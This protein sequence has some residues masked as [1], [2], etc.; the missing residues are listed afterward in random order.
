MWMRNLQAS[1]CDLT[2]AAGE[3]ECVGLSLVKLKQNRINNKIFF[4][5]IEQNPDSLYH[6]F[7]NVQNKIQDLIDTK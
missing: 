3:T 6:I 7:Y 5:E 4:V 1:V 2:L